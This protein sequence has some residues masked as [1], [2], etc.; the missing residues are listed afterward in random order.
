VRARRNGVHRVYSYVERG[1]YAAQIERLLS[2]FPREQ[3]FVLRTDRLWH[4]P[5]PVL[6]EIESFLGLGPFLEGH[7]EPRYVVPHDTRSIAGAT[8]ADFATLLA[9]FED[10]I[11][12]TAALTGLDLSDWL[13]PAYEESMGREP[14]PAGPA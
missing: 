14:A 9:L 8:E 13:D 10:D 3:V 5:G 7:L 2:L 4:E 6:S 1:F 11:R 12:R